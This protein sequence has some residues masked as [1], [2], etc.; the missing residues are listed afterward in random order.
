MTE[1][2]EG[3]TQMHEL[4]KGYVEAGF[5]QEQALRLVGMVLQAAVAVS[6]GGSPPPQ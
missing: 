4:F 3:A 2:Q 5:T 1:L 6:L